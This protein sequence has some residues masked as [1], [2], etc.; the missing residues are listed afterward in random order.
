MKK[1]MLSTLVAVAL[2]GTGTYA[3]ENAATSQS[4][5]AKA[6][7][8]AKAR[9]ADKAKGIKVVQEAVDAV[10]LTREVLTQLDQGKKDEAIKTLEKAIGKLEV[11]MSAPDAPELI[12]L[13]AQVLV[14]RFAGTPNDAENA[15]IMATALLQHHKVQ[16]A[17]VLLDTLKDEIDFVTV[18]LPLASYPAALKL[19]AKFL[20]EGNVKAARHVIAAALNTFVEVDLVTP[21]GIVQAQDLI[22]AASKIAKKDKKAALAYLAAAKTALKKSEALG[23]T[24][25]S[26]TTYK[27]LIDQIS[28]IEKEVR[29]KN[30]AA[31]LFD[32]LIESLK[33]FKDKAV[34]S[35][36]K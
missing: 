32:K 12:P 8:H 23:Y 31:K 16:D 29:G 17:R 36:T 3:K 28:A 13:S 30:E 11:V 14:D 24:S 15:V 4:I 27:M 10:K 25:A 5:S 9:A 1:T 34:K 18:N 26:D 7:T 33:E 19:A 35:F 21:I 20:H 6:I 2:L 22:A